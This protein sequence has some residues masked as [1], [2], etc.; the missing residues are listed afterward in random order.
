M[1]FLDPA[2]G[3]GSFYSST[4]KAFG[5]SNIKKAV[6]FEI[7]PS[8]GKAASEL[9]KDR[10]LSVELKDFT[11]AKP[12]TEDDRKFD[13]II[14]NPPY[15]RHHLIPR[16]AKERLQGRIREITEIHTSQLMG[17]YGLFLLISTP[18]MKQGGIGCWLIPGEF[19]DVNYGRSLKNFF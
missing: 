12:P 7:D 5:L 19:L 3:T 8:Y 14:C 2:L 18:W 15:V 6:G 10:H 13:L 1:T 9:W 11:S 16:D 17:L 4:V